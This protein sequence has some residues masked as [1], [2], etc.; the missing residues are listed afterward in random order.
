MTPF[1]FIVCCCRAH[2]QSSPEQSS[3]EHFTELDWGAIVDLAHQNG[4]VSLLYHSLRTHEQAVP[5]EVQTQ[6]H[7]AFHH[8]LRQ[9]FRLVAAL[10]QLLPQFEQAQIPV[11]PIKGPI[12]AKSL[13]GNFALRRMR[14]L[15]LLVHPQDA[16]RV[17]AL[18]WQQG[19]RCYDRL[20]RAQLQQR[21]RTN[22]ENALVHP[23]TQIQID[24]HWGIV[25]RYYACQ[26]SPAELFATAQP[27]RFQGIDCLTSSPAAQVM[28]LCLNGLK[29]GWFELQRL[30]D[31]ALF[32][33]RHP[34]L[35]WT[36][37]LSLAHRKDGD[38]AFLLGGALAQVVLRVRLPQPLA[39]AIES[40]RIVQTHCAALQQRLSNPAQQAWSLW[41]QTVLPLQLQRRGSSQVYSLVQLT[42]PLTERDIIWDALPR[43]LYWLY[44]PW[45]LVRLLRKALYLLWCWSGRSSTL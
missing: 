4:V 30:C 32:F 1:Q 40:D 26:L 22:T 21:L 42:V 29:E 17:H 44:Y 5:E 9:N 36:A 2:W 10:R 34:D 41:N 35:D 8:Q 11:L 43:S 20:S 31:L 37:L 12:L 13:Y 14:D 18:L 19:Y 7:Q 23:Q 6:L 25:P 45:R 33:Q 39:Q 38:R 15:D 3:P 28:I 16:W 27:H 24:L